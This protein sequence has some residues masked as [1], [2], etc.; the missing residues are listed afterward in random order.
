MFT[1]DTAKPEQEN[2]QDQPAQEASQGAKEETAKPVQVKPE[3]PAN[4]PV[5]NKSMKKKWYYRNLKYY[6]CKGC[7]TTDAKKAKAEA[8][9]KAAPAA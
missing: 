3:K 6:C 9:Q 5:C 4:C 1:D 7:W 2:N 8:E